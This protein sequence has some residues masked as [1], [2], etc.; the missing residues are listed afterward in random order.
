MML[1][2]LVPSQI[3]SFEQRVLTVFSYIIARMLAALG[4]SG[5]IHERSDLNTSTTWFP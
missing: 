1:Y 2:A 3:Q 4:N 5:A